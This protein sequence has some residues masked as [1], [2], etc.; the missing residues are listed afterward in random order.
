MCDRKLGALVLKNLIAFVVLL[1]LTDVSYAEDWK[2]RDVIID[3]VQ[4]VMNPNAPMIGLVHTESK[5]HWRAGGD[6]DDE[7][8]FARIGNVVMDDL[9][10]SY[11]LDSQLSTVQVISV[12][13]DYVRSLG[14]IGDGP[15]EFRS[16]SGVSR[17]RDG[18][19]CVFQ[20]MPGRAVLLEPNGDSKGDHPLPKGRDGGFLYLNGGDVASDVLVVKLGE[21]MERETSI[22]LKTS[23]AA[24]DASGNITTTYWESVQE[25]DLAKITFDEKTDAAPIW[26]LGPDGSLYINNNWDEY[27]IQVID[28]SGHTVRVIKRDYN[29]RV[30]ND[31]DLK[32]IEKQI[33]LGE[34]SSETDISKTSRAVVRIVPRL[35]GRVWVLS[36]RGA[37]DIPDGVVGTFDEYDRQGRFVRQVSVS[38]PYRRGVDEFFVVDDYV[39]VASN[40]GECAGV[41]EH[42]GENLGEIEVTCLSIVGEL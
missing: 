6:D 18:T 26:A 11:I 3:G 38:A 4:H 23:F 22:A 34:L 29:D 2:G 15:G 8:M 27:S 12:N 5:E 13:G 9:G 25:Q 40:A 19:V 39:Y 14:R 7:V 17:F 20:L 42:E 35:N 30:R 1:F 21:L 37:M 32:C 16:P 36:G 31:N 33:E 24:L 41:F 10:N 28:K